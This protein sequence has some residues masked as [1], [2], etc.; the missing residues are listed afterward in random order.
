VRRKKREGREL[1]KAD[2]MDKAL[3]VAPKI[4]FF[5]EILSVIKDDLSKRKGG[6]EVKGLKRFVEIRAGPTRGFGHLNGAGPPLV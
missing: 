6:L 5:E 1:T 4:V 2:L 3:H